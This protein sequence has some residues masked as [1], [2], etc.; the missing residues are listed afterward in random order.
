MTAAGNVLVIG[1]FLQ[2]RVFMVISRLD[3]FSRLRMTMPVQRE[4]RVDCR[5]RHDAEHCCSRYQKGYHC[6]DGRR[7][8]GPLERSSERLPEKPA[9]SDF[10]PGNKRVKPYY[11][12]AA[13]RG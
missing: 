4:S 13:V 10:E 3:V 1:R 9:K 6:G 12:D 7:G 8:K 2:R 11:G 5:S